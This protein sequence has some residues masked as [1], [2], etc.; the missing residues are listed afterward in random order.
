V[1][2]FPWNQATPPPGDFAIVDALAEAIAHAETGRGYAPMCADID[3]AMAVYYV[4][5]FLLWCCARWPRD[6]T[7]G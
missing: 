4:R 5:R 3:G 2:Q 6:S 7:N 1:S